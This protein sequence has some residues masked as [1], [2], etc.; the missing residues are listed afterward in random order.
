MLFSWTSDSHFSL[1][2]CKTELPS[3]R[4]LPLTAFVVK[5]NVSICS[6]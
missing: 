4:N 5:V 1:N 6:P 2:M 3:S